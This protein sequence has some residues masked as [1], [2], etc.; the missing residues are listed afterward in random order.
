MENKTQLT[1]LLVE[2]MTSWTGGTAASVCPELQQ[3]ETSQQI[4]PLLEA[5]RSQAKMLRC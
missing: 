2:M 1:E 4:I 5:D 3:T